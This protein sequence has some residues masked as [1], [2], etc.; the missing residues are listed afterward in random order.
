M[1]LA[2][3]SDLHFGSVPRE[4]PAA[5]TEALAYDRP[6]L[7]ALAGDL[8]LSASANEFEA[9]RNW[10]RSLE[11]P[12]LAVPGNHDIPR[13]MLWERFTNPF[14]RFQN[15]T[16]EFASEPFAA[17]REAVV[18]GFNTV[19][20]AQPNLRWHEGLARRACIE[21]AS[22]LLQAAPASTFRAVLAHHPFA[23]IEGVPR[24]R[25]VR[26]AEAALRAF[27][28]AGVELIM[29]GHTH[30]SFAQRISVGRH[31]LLMVGAPT[32][33]S[34][35]TRGEPNG[36]W[37]LSI[38]DRAIRCHLFSWRRGRFRPVNLTTFARPTS[39]YYENA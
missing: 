10:L 24:A 17:T 37:N 6:D 23:R 36:F 22:A 29:T 28:D 15:S 12:V 26:N 38:E 30:L 3:L 7:V 16:A 27:A 21:T 5:L 33:L 35:R 9:A 31:S 39:P 25:P 19:A 11:C 4:L 1:K 14:Q 18:I 32:A 8:T 34:R 13:F 20:K 2:L